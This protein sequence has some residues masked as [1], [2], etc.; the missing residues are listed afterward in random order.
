MITPP[1]ILQTDRGLTASKRMSTIQG[2]LA[3]SVSISATL[4]A[5]AAAPLIT[6]AATTSVATAATTTPIAAAAAP[7]AVL[8]WLRLVDCQA[9]SAMLLVVKS[10]N[11]RE[12]IGVGRHFDKAKATTS[13]RLAI[14]D[15]LGTSHLAKRREQVFQIGIRD[16][17]REIADIQLLAHLQPPEIWDMLR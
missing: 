10:V 7:T 17:E 15:H 8:T 13:T 1:F 5:T 6:A 11:G 12:R 2:R 4:I 3:R 14:L 9:A 16:R